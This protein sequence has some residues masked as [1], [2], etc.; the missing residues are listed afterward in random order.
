MEIY[1]Q[2]SLSIDKPRGRKIKK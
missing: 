1:T 2:G